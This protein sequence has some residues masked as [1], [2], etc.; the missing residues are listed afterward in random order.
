[1]SNPDSAVQ[2]ILRG[3]NGSP[4]SLQNAKDHAL[5]NAVQ[6]RKAE[7]AYRAAEGSVRREAGAFDPELFF[8]LSHLDQQQPT[9]SFFAGAPVLSTQQTTSRSGLRMKLPVGTEL[10]L[11]M[12]TSKLATNSTFAF[13]NPEYDVFGTVSFRQPLMGGFT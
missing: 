8:N 10:E 5:A 12:N 2:A 1:M 6:V 4:L 3:L 11:A 9:A 13:L 7:A